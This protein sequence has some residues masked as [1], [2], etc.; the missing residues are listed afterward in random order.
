MGCA[1][2]QSQCA[3]TRVAAPTPAQ[4][5]GLSILALQ[6]LL[7]HLK[8]VPPDCV[9]G[10]LSWFL[11]CENLPLYTAYADRT[12]PCGY[13]RDSRSRQ[14][15]SSKAGINQRRGNPPSWV[16][17]KSVNLCSAALPL[18]HIP[19]MSSASTVLPPDCA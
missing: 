8:G 5:V 15:R 12:A 14:V 16:G 3:A 18:D 1:L 13:R 6:L 19:R 9:P 17:A 2:T 11:T 10:V 4:V 7:P